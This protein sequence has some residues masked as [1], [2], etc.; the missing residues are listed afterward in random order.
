MTRTMPPRAAD[1]DL[2]PRAENRYVVKALELI[3]K[4]NASFEP[5]LLSL[6]GTR[7]ELERCVRLK[8][9]VE[10]RVAKLA[11]RLDDAQEVAAAAGVSMGR[12][13]EA[14]ATGASLKDSDVLSGALQ[15]GAISLEQAGEIA[16]AEASRP[17][18]AEA[19][20]GVAQGSSFQVLREKAR[21]VVLEAEQHRGL[22]ARQ[23]AARSGRPYTDALGMVHIHLALEPHVG[24]PIVARAEAEAAR[25]YRAAK[26]EAKGSPDKSL[27][28]YERY[29]ADAYARMLVGRGK[30]S[31]TRP[32]L[33]VLVSHEVV[34]RG[35]TDVR[36]GEVCKKSTLLPAFAFPPPT[37]NR[38]FGAWA[39]SV[40]REIAGDAF[41]SGVL[42]D[43][44]DLR[45][46]KRWTR[47]IPVEVR[48]ALELGEGPAFD[49]PCCTDCGKRFKT[50]KDHVEPHVCLGPSSTGNIKWRCYPCHLA[51]TVADR[52][53]GKL[54]RPPD[55]RPKRPPPPSGP[56]P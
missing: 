30:R 45:H 11:A 24:T 31:T 8:R 41:L 9:L 50:E 43:G 20:V 55:A 52:K 42:Y 48:V 17:G 36:A 47:N 7:D 25:L 39:P 44:K 46:F 49:G 32:E 23:R 34:K 37:Q 22:A 51:K 40:A 13:K 26:A 15:S 29:V 53:A 4:A 18:A 54:R 2:S 35:W 12:A 33:V 3:E 6:Q 56:D 19:L 16:K 14:L 21:A 28:P 1:G 10:Y 27:E 38:S 5:E